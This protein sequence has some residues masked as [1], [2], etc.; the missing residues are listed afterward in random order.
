MRLGLF[1]VYPR[2]GCSEFCDFEGLCRYAAWR[3][4][5]KWDQHPL[6]PLQVIAGDADEAGEEAD[7]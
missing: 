1:P 2:G 4:D 6:E 3:I 5:R 7:A